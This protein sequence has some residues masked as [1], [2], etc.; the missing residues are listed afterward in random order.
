[1]VDVYSH[2]E[3]T[4]STTKL[5]VHVSAKEVSDYI[6]E[7]AQTVLLVFLLLMD[8]VLLVQYILLLIQSLELVNV[9]LVSHF[10]VVNVL[11]LVHLVKFIIQLLKHASV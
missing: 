7:F 8:I 2:V 4:K 5:L 9:I 6:K 11:L 10:L 1:M 3:L